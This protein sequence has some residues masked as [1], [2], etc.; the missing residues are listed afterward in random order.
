VAFDDTLS[1]E[2]EPAGDIPF[3]SFLFVAL[4]STRPLAGSARYALANV[5]EVSIGRGDAR[6]DHKIVDGK[7]RLELRFP[8]SRLSGEHASVRR[9]DERFELTD[10][11]SKNGSLVNGTTQRCVQLCDSDLIQLGNTFFTFRRLRARPAYVTDLRSDG[12]GDAPDGLLTVMPQLSEQFDRFALVAAADLPIMIIGETGTGKELMAKAAHTLSQRKGPFVPVNCGALA[13]SLLESELF[14]HKRGAFSGAN[15]DRPGLVR[16]SDGGT[17]FL[18]EVAELPAAAQTA[19]LRAL[20][21]REVRPVGGVRAV[22]VDLRIVCATHRNLTES[23]DAG[24]FRADLLARLG[25]FVLRLPTLRERR[26]DLGLLVSTLLR[27]FALE[28]CDQLR[29]SAAA[30]RQLL[31]DPWPMNIRA[32]EKCIAA[33]L[34]SCEG[35]IET[36]H[37]ALSSLMTHSPQ[38][39]SSKP[40]PA[41]PQQLSDDDAER[42]GQLVRLL[43]Q[44]KGNISAVAR[45]MGKDRVQVRRWLRRYGLS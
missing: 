21:E 1:A 31:T 26:E 11:G 43:E 3:T 41:V 30:A 40:A 5:D 37:L 29:L 4:E 15:E 8:D 34:L 35:T 44:H 17:L 18:D 19:L 22:P 24:R 39:A 20:Q 25:G 10:L 33:A 14:G 6:A 9:D 32:L 36:A 42:R 7:R 45:E 27:R 28:R 12:Q 13:P 38:P 23:V 16:A 2:V